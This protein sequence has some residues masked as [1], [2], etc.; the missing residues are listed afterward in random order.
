MTIIRPRCAV[1]GALVLWCEDAWV[2]DDVKGCGSEW[3]EQHSVMYVPP[4]EQPEWESVKAPRSNSVVYWRLV[5]RR[6]AVGAIS[7][8]TRTG[9]TATNAADTA[10]WRALG[11]SPTGQPP[12][13]NTELGMHEHRRPAEDAVLTHWEK[14]YGLAVSDR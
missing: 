11:Y 7:R 9:R 13:G 12:T 8:R 10:K 1:C 3:D 6:R 14:S 2:C 5:F 4:A